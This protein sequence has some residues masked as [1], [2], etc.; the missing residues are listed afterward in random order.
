MS[1]WCDKV[2][3]LTML[4]CF[5]NF[6]RPISHKS[7]SIQLF[8]FGMTML[9][10]GTACDKYVVIPDPNAYEHRF[11]TVTGFSAGGGHIL[12]FTSTRE[13]PVEMSA[14]GDT[15]SYQ[16]YSK[17][18]YEE[19]E[20]LLDCQLHK[21]NNFSYFLQEFDNG[22]PF[23]YDAF[24]NLDGHL[25]IINTINNSV[26]ANINI[27][28]NHDGKQIQ[29]QSENCFETNIFGTIIYWGTAVTFEELAANRIA[30]KLDLC[31]PPDEYAAVDGSIH[32]EIW[33]GEH[34]KPANSKLL[35]L[36][37]KYDNVLNLPV[38]VFSE[39]NGGIPVTFDQLN[40]MDASLKIF[41]PSGE[42][43]KEIPFG[44]NY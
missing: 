32:A 43:F 13:G 29:Y 15:L 7:N 24:V 26:I 42:L 39:L 9:L 3:Y 31:A 22:D 10:I 4:Q 40:K 27:G 18:A 17:S 11:V 8:V 2:L 5:K 25:K 28:A 38:G 35:D 19:G 6:N 20:L 37:M 36:E 34:Q 12:N 1:Y 33:S 41:T 44:V 14:F 16:I 21:V 30:C 23:D